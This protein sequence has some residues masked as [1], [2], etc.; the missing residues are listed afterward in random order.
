MKDDN[1]PLLRTHKSTIVQEAIGIDYDTSNESLTS[2]TSEYIDSD[3]YDQQLT[4]KNLPSSPYKKLI[5]MP[6]VIKDE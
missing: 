3:A 4:M 2:L 5:L 6:Q 1:D